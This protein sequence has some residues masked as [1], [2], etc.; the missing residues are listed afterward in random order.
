MLI[1]FFSRSQA[2]LV[3]QVVPGQVGLDQKKLSLW[4]HPY[5][6]PQVLLL[7][8]EYREL[9]IVYMDTQDKVLTI[10]DRQLDS[11]SWKFL[12]HLNTVEEELGG[13]DDLLKDKEVMMVLL[14]KS[15]DQEAGHQR[16]N[17]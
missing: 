15:Q 14:L 7:L 5:S 2:I 3:W 13:E 11:I 4:V 6:Q 10:L 16:R 8:A 1:G 12:L 9:L 17:V